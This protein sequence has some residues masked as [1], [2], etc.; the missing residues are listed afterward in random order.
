[1][2]GTILLTALAL[3]TLAPQDPPPPQVAP[4]PQAAPQDLS[5]V[6]IEG[7][8]IHEEAEA[9]VEEVAA[10]AVDRGLAR[11]RSRICVGVGNL[12]PDLSQAVID[13]ISRVAL[14]YGIAVG[15]PGCRPNVMIVFAEDGRAMATALVEADRRVFHLGVGGLDRGKAAL[16]DFRNSEAPVRWWHVSMPMI[17]GS[18]A[19][20]I[21]LPGDTAPI[22]VP[23]EGYVN[24]GRP[25]SDALNKVIIIV[26][27]DQLA[28]ANY[29]QLCEYLAMVALAQVDPDG[30]TSRHDTILNVFNDPQGVQGLTEWDRAYLTTLYAHHPERIEP[31]WQASRLARGMIRARS[32]AAEEAAGQ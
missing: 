9:F 26:D 7:R 4:A 11:W 22:F 23:G 10:P 5:D 28:G 12:Q 20:A 31:D 14:E 6:V 15:E 24:R 30:D 25:I 18:S 29:A 19:R 2:S 27:A 32:E 8:R 1:M 17:G 13:H 21:R 16:E 3:L